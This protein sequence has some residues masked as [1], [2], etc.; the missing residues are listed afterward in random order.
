MWVTSFSK[1]KENQFSPL[2]DSVVDWVTS[3]S[4]F[5]ICTVMSFNFVYCEFRTGREVP[6]GSL[7]PPG[8]QQELSDVEGTVK[9]EPLPPIGSAKTH[10]SNT[11]NDVT[12]G[13]T[14][15]K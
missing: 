11:V 9:N 10:K 4:C 15:G 2:V 8:N 14:E 5:V 1:P 3:D 7:S 13:S 6:S 12:I